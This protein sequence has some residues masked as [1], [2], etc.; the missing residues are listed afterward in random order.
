LSQQPSRLTFNHIGIRVSNLKSVVAFFIETLG[1]KMTGRDPHNLKLPARMVFLRL[2]DSHHDFA[3]VQALPGENPSGQ[4]HHI[5]LQV[6]YRTAVFQWF[7]A[8]Q[9]KEVPVTEPAVHGYEGNGK[10]SLPFDSG[11]FYTV[12]TGPENIRVEI[13]F[14]DPAAWPPEQLPDLSD[15]SYEDPAWIKAIYS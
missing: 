6:P 9:K 14:A 5:A 4:I 7:E 1:C 8:L 10:S 15:P 12:A 13:F 2:G 3:L 11:H